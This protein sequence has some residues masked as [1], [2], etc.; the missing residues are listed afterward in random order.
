VISREETT[1]A[2]D[3]MEV[4]EE[5]EIDHKNPLKD[6]PWSPSLTPDSLL[7]FSIGQKVWFWCK[8][9]ENVEDERSKVS[10]LSRPLTSPHISFLPIGL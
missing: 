10:P 3:A 5:T 9:K 7:T 8:R 2:R 6:K 1:R 4:E